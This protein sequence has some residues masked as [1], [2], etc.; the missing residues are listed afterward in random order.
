M[1]SQT[2]GVSAMASMTS[3]VKSCGCGEVNR[4]RRMPE[5]APTARNS[6]ANSGRREEPGTVTSRP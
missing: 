3:G 1:C 4:T 5:T 6:S 2:V